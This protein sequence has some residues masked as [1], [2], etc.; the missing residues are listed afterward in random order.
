[1]EPRKR[2]AL[3]GP[4][5]G[6]MKLVAKTILGLILW[7][8]QQDTVEVRIIDNTTQQAQAKINGYVF[9]NR[10]LRRAFEYSD[11]KIKNESNLLK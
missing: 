1:M 3:L 11:H 4:S 7:R 6:T 2:T 8:P 9:A 10:K 5:H